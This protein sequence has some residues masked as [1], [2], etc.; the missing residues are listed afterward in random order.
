MVERRNKKQVLFIWQTWCNGCTQDCGSCSMSSILIVYPITKTFSAIIEDKNIPMFRHRFKSCPTGRKAVQW[1][2]IEH[3]FIRVLLLT[4][5]PSVEKV[6][7]NEK[8]V[9]CALVAKWLKARD[10]KSRIHWF[11]SNRA[12]QIKYKVAKLVDARGVSRLNC[13]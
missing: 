2:R 4:Y 5:L 10:C 13:Y 11:K 3:L 6:S 8:I 7:Q 12:L 9:L 1:I